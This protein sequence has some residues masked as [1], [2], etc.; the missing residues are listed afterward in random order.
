VLGTAYSSTIYIS[1]SITHLDQFNVSSVT[2]TQGELLANDVTG[3]AFPVVKVGTGSGF[4]EVGETAVTIQG[5]YGTLTVNETGHYSYTPGTTI[6]HSTVNLV[7]SFTYQIVQPNGVTA[8]ATLDVTINV[9]SGATSAVMSIEEASLRMD[10]A[11][12][13]GD[14]TH[15]TASLTSDTTSDQ[16]V[17]P[18]PEARISSTF[19]E[20]ATPSTDDSTVS[21]TDLV[22]A[23]SAADPVDA[24]SADRHARL[25]RSAGRAGL[26][27]VRRS[28]RARRCA[29]HLS[30]PSA[31]TRTG[32]T[33]RGKRGAQP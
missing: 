21:G 18:V 22:A 11:A 24:P 25:R 28:G 10:E 6:P 5:T 31:A 2:G 33:G 13:V 29:G 3:T 15:Q 4:V 23:A 26:S 17:T 12:A 16:L 9:G 30:R 7:D 20:A 14:D 19:E 27:D 1:E 32:G 8:T